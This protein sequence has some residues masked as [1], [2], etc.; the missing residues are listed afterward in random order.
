[1]QGT[2]G[3]MVEAANLKLSDGVVDLS[4]IMAM[5]EHI[6]VQG[7]MYNFLSQQWVYDNILWIM[8]ALTIL[9]ALSVW[10]TYYL[11]V[12]LADVTVYNF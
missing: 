10:G 1:M 8:S 5:S 11:F 4:T 6:L 9:S 3:L 7:D 12:Y 2:S